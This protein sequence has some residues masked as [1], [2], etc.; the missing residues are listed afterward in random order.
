MTRVVAGVDTS[1]Q[2]CTIELYD[3]SDGKFLGSG[4]T[5]HPPTYPPVSEQDPHDWWNAFIL[6]LVLACESASVKPSQ[7]AAISVAG[8]CHG[9]VPLDKDLQVIR[10]AKLWNDTTSAKETNDLVTQRT[11]DSWSQE[12]LIAMN[13]ALTIT[14]LLWLR[15]HEK[16][17][18]EALHKVLL[19]HEWM[20]FKLTGKFA[21]DRSEASGTGYF[22]SRTS[23][24]RFDLLAE[25]ISADKNWKDMFADVYGPSDIVG[26]I[27][28]EISALTG[29]PTDC[30]VSAGGGDQHL[31]A[32]GMGLRVGETAFSLGTSGVV[33][34]PVREP[35]VDSRIDGVADATGGYLP[36][37]CT[38]NCTKVTDTFARIL[39]VDLKTLNDLALSIDDTS[40]N[41][42]AYLDGERTP[43]R[44]GTSGLLDGLRTDTTQADIAFAAFDGV[45]RG[46]VRSFNL[47]QSKSSTPIDD[48][49][50]IVG[51]GARSTGYKQF[52]ADRIGKDVITVNAPE[53]TARGAAIQAAAALHN[54]DIS[55]VRD[56][57][58]PE[59]IDV[60]TPRVKAPGSDER[61]LKLTETSD[62]HFGFLPERKA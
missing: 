5:P 57:W 25:H 23:K 35:V 10:K 49:V 46:L 47:L 48:R 58:T 38:L 18:F 21:T 16:D 2:S 53:A 61:Y 44:P 40:L 19:P 41:L 3:E 45:T 29:I 55:R 59:V 15:N 54:E 12:V 33:F 27:S 26:N 51:G 42:V 13:P 37:L 28:S 52:I 39:G 9:L 6:S 56:I 60:T 7:I 36:L 8:Q 11:Q 22:D 50:I 32:V 4:R 24:Y 31:A 17:N 1:T 14:K 62:F 20:T 43:S 30:V 34:T